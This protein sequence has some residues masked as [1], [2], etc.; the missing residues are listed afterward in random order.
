MQLIMLQFTLAHFLSVALR[1]FP[2]TIFY[3]SFRMKYIFIRFIY[4][5]ILEALVGVA[6]EDSFLMS[7]M[8]F[9]SLS[10]LTVT[11]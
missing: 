9:G 10:P 3:F 4:F 2:A 7:K 11:F 5:L 6:V 1:S 8:Y